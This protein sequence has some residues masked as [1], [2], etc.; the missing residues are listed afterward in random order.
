MSYEDEMRRDPKGLAKRYAFCPRNYATS[1]DWKFNDDQAQ[2]IPL[3]GEFTGFTQIG[4]NRDYLIAKIRLEIG[5]DRGNGC[6]VVHPSV[7]RDGKGLPVY[8]LPWDGRGAAVCMKIPDKDPTLKEIDHPTIFFTAVLSGCSIIFKGTAQKPVI[9]HCGTGGTEGGGTPTKGNSNDF[10]Q[11][12]VTG[13]GL[14]PVAQIIKSSDYMV[15]KIGSDAVSNLQTRY[16]SSLNNLG[17]TRGFLFKNVTAWGAC[18][19]VRSGRDWKF[20]VQK[21]GTIEYTKIE[22][23]KS[24]TPTDSKMIS[25]KTFTLGPYTKTS[26]KEQ[27]VTKVNKD[28]LIAKPIEVQRVFPGPGNVKLGNTWAVLDI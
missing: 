11:N 12:M 3:S 27:Y 28:C 14:M 18:F 23:V 13:P 15:P 6:L 5:N 20:Y 8:F 16:L 24:K 21:N 25:T 7:G 1:S 17:Q 26:V 9:F 22:F 2:K 4:I 10:F 19:G